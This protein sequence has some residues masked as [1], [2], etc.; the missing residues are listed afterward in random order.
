MRRVF[1]VRHGNTFDAGDEILRVGGRTDLPLSSSG[2][3]QAE[4][5]TMVFKDMSFAKAYSSDLKRTKMTAAAILESRNT[6]L[7][8]ADFL[9]EIDYGPDEGRPETEVVARLG[10]ATLNRWDSDAIPPADW[11]VDPDD[12]RQA[13]V[14]FLATLE[15]D[16]DDILVV[17]SNGVAR[18]VLDVIAG[19][20]NAGRKLKTGAYG[21]IQLT[22]NGPELATWNIRP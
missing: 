1:I 10:Q 15:R 21:V 17:T 9:T 16:G 12:L 11:K 14:N 19:G 13:W 6:P 7:E 22:V 3:K 18:F 5:L 20:Q 2:L 4:A 8:L